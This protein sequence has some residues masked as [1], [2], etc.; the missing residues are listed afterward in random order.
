MNPLTAIE[1]GMPLALAILALGMMSSIAGASDRESMTFFLR[2]RPVAF[3]VEKENHLNYSQNCLDRQ[4]KV[5]C[6]VLLQLSRYNLRELGK[7]LQGVEPGVAL[8]TR[9]L[10]GEIAIARDA[11]G[12]ETSF[13]ALPDSTFIGT[14]T[15]TYYASK[16]EL[17]R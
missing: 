7:P 8:C 16:N 5:T 15:L 11:R 6:K 17:S 13:C 4:G 2:G 14:G 9:I 10:G 1:K 12:N 3:Y